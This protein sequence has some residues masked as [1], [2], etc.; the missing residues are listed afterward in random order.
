QVRARAD[1]ADRQ[2]LPPGPDQELPQLL[3]VAGAREPVGIAAGADRGQPR[4][5]KAVLGS[6]GRGAHPAALF[7]TIASPTLKMSPAPTV[8]ST[9]PGSRRDSSAACAFPKLGAQSTRLP[10]IR[11]AAA[12]ATSR[13]LMPAR[14]PTGSSRAGYTSST[15]T[16]SASAKAAPNC[17]ASALVRE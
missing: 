8:T 3:G 16:S 6:G 5:G 4:K 7:P 1:H 9:A 10:S 14:S 15:T 2:A 12:R 11:S 13:P 17:S